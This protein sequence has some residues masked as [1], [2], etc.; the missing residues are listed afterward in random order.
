M[1]IMI[2]VLIAVSS[3]LYTGYT[4]VRPSRKALRISYAFVAATLGSGTYLVVTMHSP[5][6]SACTTG[7]L[8]LAVVMAGILAARHKLVLA[9]QID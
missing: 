3:L 2:H 5:L 4:Y 6:L 9:E 7:L 1:L 8:Y